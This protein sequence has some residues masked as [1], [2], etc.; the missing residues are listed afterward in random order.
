MDALAVYTVSKAAR[1]WA[2]AGNGPVLIETVT[3]RFGAHSMSGDDPKR[4]RSEESFEKWDKKDPLTRMRIY[5]TDKGLWNEEMEEKARAQFDEEIQEAVKKADSAPEQ[6]ISS[7]LKSMYEEPTDLL[8][9]QI[10]YYE[11]KEGNN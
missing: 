1:E 4:Y 10:E 6:K 2:L 5:L 9:E 11:K 3:S 8:K 7:F